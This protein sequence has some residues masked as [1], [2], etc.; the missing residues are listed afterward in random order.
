MDFISSLPETK[1]GFNVNGVV[2]DR[3]TKI[4]HSISGRPHIE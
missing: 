2:R 3:P 4:A 1:Q